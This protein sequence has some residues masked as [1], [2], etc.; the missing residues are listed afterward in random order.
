MNIP[1]YFFGPY[2]PEV[3]W[4]RGPVNPSTLAT[5]GAGSAAGLHA[6]EGSVISYNDDLG[7]FV[8]YEKFKF[9]ENKGF[10]INGIPFVTLEDCACPWNPTD[11]FFLALRSH[12]P[13]RNAYFYHAQLEHRGLPTTGSVEVAKM[14]LLLGENDDKVKDITHIDIIKEQLGLE[15]AHILQD[16]RRGFLFKGLIPLTI[17]PQRLIEGP[18]LAEARDVAAKA[19]DRLNELLLANGEYEDDELSENDSDITVIP[20]IRSVKP[21]TF[22]GRFELVGAPNPTGSPTTPSPRTEFK[23]PIAAGE[24]IF[25]LDAPSDTL[26]GRFRVS[27]GPR[28]THGVFAVPAPRLLSTCK[29]PCHIAIERIKKNAD[30]WTITHP[31]QQNVGGNYSY[32]GA[33]IRFLA[34]D[35]LVLGPAFRGPAG[36]LSYAL[37]QDP[38]NKGFS[39]KDMARLEGMERPALFKGMWE[40]VHFAWCGEPG[41]MGVD[42]DRNAD[43]GW[44]RVVLAGM[45][46]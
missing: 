1:P 6:P 32:H 33:W 11:G 12:G 29:Q 14:R 21:D 10:L 34:P 7:Y 13:A 43:Q 2:V 16:P 20:S 42:G 46:N 23:I 24:I 30:D 31:A 25:I 5:H 44:D 9:S 41:C 38:A 19:N 18:S 26:Y 8:R 28:T 36:G 39:S 45:L 35:L 40:D 4:R 3:D 27:T 15:L 22:E 17:H 37:K